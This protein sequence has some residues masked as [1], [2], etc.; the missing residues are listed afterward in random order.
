MDKEKEANE[1][2]RVVSSIARETIEEFVSEEKPTVLLHAVLRQK[3][4]KLKRGDVNKTNIPIINYSYDIPYET[5]WRKSIYG[6][7]Y[8][9]YKE[10]SF[11]Q[12]LNSSIY[13]DSKN[14]PTG[15]FSL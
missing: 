3:F 8:P 2:F 9:S 15:K 12:Y 5:D 10:E 6:P 1:L 11:D 13:S 14:A 7:R 4:K